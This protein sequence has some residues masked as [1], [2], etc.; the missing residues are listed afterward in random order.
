MIIEKINQSKN[1]VI[2]LI[3]IPGSGKSTLSKSLNANRINMDTIRLENP[4]LDKGDQWEL[5]YN[6]FLDFLKEDKNIVIDNTNFMKQLR[7]R[8]MFYIPQ[9]WKKIAIVINTPLD[10]CIRRNELR[11]G[12]ARVPE[13]VIRDMYN[14]FQRPT[15]QEGFDEIYDM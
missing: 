6:Q 4:D 1:T 3:G 9:E 13:K 8:Y 7:N 5:S 11:T 12:Q 15:F 10:E 14:K 2:F